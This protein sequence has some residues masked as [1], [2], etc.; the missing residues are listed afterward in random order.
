RVR[1]AERNNRLAVGHLNTHLQETLSGVEVIRAFGREAAFAQRFR[2][3]LREALAAYNRATVY[4][5]LYTPLMAILSALVVALLLWVG[6][7]NSLTARNISLG[8]L[9]A[10]VLLFRRFFTP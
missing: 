3:A 6:S 7:L 10:F 9:T 5:S 1:E 4:A 2:L 8:T